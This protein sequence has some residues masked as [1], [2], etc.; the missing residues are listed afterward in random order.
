[1]ATQTNVREKVKEVLARELKVGVEE[2]ED[3]KRIGEDLGADSLQRTELVM[4]LEEAFEIEMPDDAALQ[5]LTV[6]DVLNFIEQ[7]VSSAG[8]KP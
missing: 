8:S 4:I 3:D 5:L 7:K 6:G 1:M 2:L